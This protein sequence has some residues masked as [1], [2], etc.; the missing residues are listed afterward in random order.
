MNRKEHWETVYTKN[1]DTQVSWYQPDPEISFRLI[2]K[3][4]PGKGSVIDIG[5]GT[6]RLA[7]KL[8]EHGYKDVAVLDISATAVAK[9]KARLAQRAGLIQWIV[10][11]ITQV[12]HV[13]QFD[14]WHDRAG[15]HFLGDP[16]DRKRYVDLAGRTLRKGGRLVI[17]TF[18]KDGPA[19][20]SGL[21]VCRY[22]RATLAAEFMPF[23]CAAEETSHLHHTPSGKPQQFIFF[24]LERL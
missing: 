17:G 15:F 13:G 6:S 12:Q 23:F 21:D 10:G 14:V 22:D 19:R 3:A 4:S 18:A 2:E 20:C 16:A 24:T 7:E 11:D 8:L 9:A 5:G 1:D